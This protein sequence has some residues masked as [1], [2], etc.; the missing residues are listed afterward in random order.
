LYGQGALVVASFGSS[1]VGFLIIGAIVLGFV[2]NKQAKTRGAGNANV[3]IVKVTGDQDAA[4]T[5][6][7]WISQGW[8]VQSHT[9]RKASYSA[10]A[11]VFTR[12]QIHTI[13]FVRPGLS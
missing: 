7:Q 1:L 12:K 2:A 10:M 9:T 5:I 13:T 8:Q 4:N 6:S 3:R 11:G